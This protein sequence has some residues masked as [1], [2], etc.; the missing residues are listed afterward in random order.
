MLKV[1]YYYNHTIK[2]AP[3]KEAMIE[4]ENEIHKTKIYSFIDYVAIN[5]G[6]TDGFVSKTVRGYK[7]FEIRIKISKNLYRILYFIWQERYLILLSMF[8]KKEGEITPQKQIN[9]AETNY[10]NFI[11]YK[12]FII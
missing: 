1:A 2:K 6:L 4:I 12:K 5:R 11:K 9:I 7:F 10:S 3:V 8:T